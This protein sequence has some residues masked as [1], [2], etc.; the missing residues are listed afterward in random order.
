MSARPKVEHR[1][2]NM[3]FDS[4]RWDSFVPRD[5]DV[6]VCTSY[7]AGTTWTQMICALLIHKTPDLPL[8][9]AELSPWLDIRV[10]AIEEVVAA[11]ERQPFRRIIKTHTGLDGLPY[12]DN[13]TYL[14]C[15]RDPRDVFMSLQSHMAN[16]DI[17]QAI[18]L[19]AAQGVE[20][21]I[22]PPLPEDINERFR[23][24]ATTGSFEWEHDGLPFWSHL[25][26]G[27][28]FWKHRQLPNIQF[29]HYADLKADLPAQ[30][31]RLA[32]LLDEEIGEDSWPELVKAAGFDSMKANA[33]RTAPDTD[34]K[35]YFD[36]SRFFHKGEIGQWRG[37]LDE[38]SLQLYRRET[39]TR[40]DPAMVDWL[41]RG[42][43]AA[44]DPKQAGA[45]R[46]RLL[47]IS[48]T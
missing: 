42:S 11:L 33:D 25:H 17:M 31:R 5:G 19:L 14:V 32:K 39:L 3:I 23:V 36:N 21:S 45:Q 46:G 43:L 15:G 10:K 13:V 9:L 27:E 12:Y 1:Y 41:E 24:W 34:Y 20:L 22:P 40:Y 38:E 30:M 37:V 2:R 47:E 26:H 44:G 4:G 48:K 28:T 7:K 16:A 29:L 35:L 18:R 6:I 8:P